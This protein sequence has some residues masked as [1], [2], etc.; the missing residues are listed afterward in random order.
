MTQIVSYP[1]HRRHQ[2]MLHVTWITKKIYR[3]IQYITETTLYLKKAITQA[4]YTHPNILFSFQLTYLAFLEI[5]FF[6]RLG[7]LDFKPRNNQ[8]CS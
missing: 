2:L 5:I 1:E 7:Y 3:D 8:V 4:A 6:S